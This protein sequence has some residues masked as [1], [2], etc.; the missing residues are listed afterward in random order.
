MK[1]I[2]SHSLSETQKIAAKYAR[3]LKGVGGI[4]TLSGDLGSGKTA[5]VQG[6]AQALGV[7]QRVL[8]PSYTLIRSYTVPDSES[9]LYHIDL[10]RL[11]KTPSLDHLG[12]SE[13]FSQGNN[14]ILI[15]WPDRLGGLLPKKH[16][17]IELLYISPNER[18]IVIQ[19]TD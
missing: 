8:S 17:N 3:S 1:K 14:Y 10:Y 19:S 18:E 12:L 7:K 2:H 5:F 4:I 13:I 9:T 6:F 16:T 15:E 11:E